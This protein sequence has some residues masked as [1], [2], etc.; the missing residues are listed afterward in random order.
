MF[1]TNNIISNTIWHPSLAANTSE[2]NKSLPIEKFAGQL[3]FNNA[4]IPTEENKQMGEQMMLTGQKN[5]SISDLWTHVA[6]K[7]FSLQ[8]AEFLFFSQSLL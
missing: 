1:P 8:I 5:G 3:D 4:F 2:V 6:L 7:K